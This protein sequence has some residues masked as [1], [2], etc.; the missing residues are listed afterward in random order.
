MIRLL[1]S[2]VIVMFIAATAFTGSAFAQEARTDWLDIELG[3]SIIIAAPTNARAIA[4]TDPEI[5][6]VQTL[7][8]NSSQLQ[9]QGKQV[10]STDFIVQLSSG[11]PIIYEITVHQD[12]SDLIRRIDGIVDGEPPQVYPLLERI[13]VQGP[14]DDLDTLEAIAGVARIFDPEFVNLMSDSS[15]Y[16][17]WC[18][19]I[20]IFA[21]CA[22]VSFT[23]AFCVKQAAESGCFVVL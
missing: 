21:G 4:I 18:H 1:M 13:V 12:L 16:F 11:P 2:Q 19:I 22:I 23:L 7:G 10:G 6:D 15:G 8:A 5:A 20:F 14:V 3:K 17:L 9:V